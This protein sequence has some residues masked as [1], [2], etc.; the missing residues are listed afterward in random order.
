MLVA[1]AKLSEKG[2][3]FKKIE[4][5]DL[6]PEKINDTLENRHTLQKQVEE[7]NKPDKFESSL[8]F[9]PLDLTKKQLNKYSHYK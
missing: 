2:I 1:H 4:N 7:V 3:S 6:L 8:D 9:M 5:I